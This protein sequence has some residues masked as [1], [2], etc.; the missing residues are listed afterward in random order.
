MYT[1]SQTGTTAR[2]LLKQAFQT[3]AR[4]AA[5]MQ[6]LLVELLDSPPEIRMP[7]VRAQQVRLDMANAAYRDA[8]D[9]YVRT[10]L[11]RRRLPR[12]DLDSTEAR[13]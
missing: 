5:A 2:A 3:C 4:Q 6:N 7:Q 8:Q 12:P 1:A 9:Q 10:V 13:R 11:G